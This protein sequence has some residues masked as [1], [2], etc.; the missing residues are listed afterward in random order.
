ML[1]EEEIMKEEIRKEILAFLGDQI[2]RN[3][4]DKNL[5]ECQKGWRL[6]DLCDACDEIESIGEEPA[7]DEFSHLVI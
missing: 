6:L 1:D 3:E 2:S 4:K 5:S 7:E